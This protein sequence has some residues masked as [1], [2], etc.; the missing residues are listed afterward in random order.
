M[1]T[2][3]AAFT[4]IMTMASTAAPARAQAGAQAGA[5]ALNPTDY[6]FIGQT[7][8]GNRF[9]VESG[10]LGETRSADPAVRRYA[11]LMDSSHVEVEAKLVALL[12]RLGVTQPP[13]SLLAGAYRSLIDMLGREHGRSFDADYVASQVVYQRSNDALYRWELA[14]G[15][16]P[17]IKA[18]ASQVLPKIDDHLGQALALAAP[19]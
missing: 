6:S 1:K 16:S 17:E 12:Q 8:L 13:A 11:S 2:K 5:M 10:R 3:V 19:R 15:S 4:A 14:N 9:Q 18:F 7:Y